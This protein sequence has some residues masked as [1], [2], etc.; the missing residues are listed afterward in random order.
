MCGDLETRAS[1]ALNIKSG[2]YRRGFPP[3][4]I[5]LIFASARF[6]ISSGNGA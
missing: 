3:K 6:T 1:L 2:N 5:E 4:V